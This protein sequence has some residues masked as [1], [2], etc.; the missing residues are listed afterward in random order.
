MKKTTLLF[1]G[2]AIT[3]LGATAQTADEIINKYADALGGKKKLQTIKN[4]YMEGSVNAQG[5]Q[6]PM[7]FWFVIK[8]SM[9]QEVT[10]NGMTQYTI[11]RNDSGWVFSP[12]QGQKQA[13]PMTADQVKSQQTELDVPGMELINYKEKGYKVTAQGKDNIDGTEVFKIEE[14]ISDSLSQTYY[15]DPETYYVI[16]VHQKATVNGKVENVNIDYSSYTKTADGFVF[17]MSESIGGGD[18]DDSGSEGG[19]V[20]FTTI[21]VNT[22]MDAKLFSPTK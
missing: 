8:K 3:A 4:I 10:F 16:R 1:A 21:K 17:P 15:I 9:R 11:V 7:K 13:E 6:I 5:Q 20:K 18:A 2:L 19:A 12:F 22:D 14:V